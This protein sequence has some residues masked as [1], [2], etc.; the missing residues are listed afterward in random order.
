MVSRG[1]F[2]GSSSTN[3]R[4]QALTHSSDLNQDKSTSIKVLFHCT[5]G[6]N[7]PVGRNERNNK[8]TYFGKHHFQ[9]FKLQVCTVRNRQMSQRPSGHFDEATRSDS[10]GSPYVQQ[11]QMFGT[12]CEL[13]NDGIGVATV[14]GQHRVGLSRVLRARY[15]QFAQLSETRSD[16]VRRRLETNHGCTKNAQARAAQLK[17]FNRYH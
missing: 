11:G 17:L 10:S 14:N 13:F 1:F 7:A 8:T 4:K 15:A 2:S 16:A 12:R 5:R 6:R 3:V 9:R